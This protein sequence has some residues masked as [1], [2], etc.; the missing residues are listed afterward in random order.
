MH[1]GGNQ[2]VRTYSVQYWLDGESLSDAKYVDGGFVFTVT[3]RYNTGEYERI[4]FETGVSGRY[5]KILPQSYVSHTSMRA[6]VM[7]CD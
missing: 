7:V 1:S 4:Y 2:W 6:G 3:R 5:F